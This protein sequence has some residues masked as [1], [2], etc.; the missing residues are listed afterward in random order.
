MS[1]LMAAGVIVS[2]CGD[3][4]D[5]SRVDNTPRIDQLPG[6]LLQAAD[7]P[8]DVH[9]VDHC[10]EPPP[11]P[12][13]TP[14]PNIHVVFANFQSDVSSSELPTC[15]FDMVSIVGS[16]ETSSQSLKTL[17]EG[18]GKIRGPMAGSEDCAVEEL[19]IP[20]LGDN[21]IA[22]GTECGS[23]PGNPPQM[24]QIGFRVGAVLVQ[25]SMVTDRC[26]VERDQAIEFARKQEQRIGEVLAGN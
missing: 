25:L 3:S 5:T 20:D 2:G 17:D 7:L 6:I 9:Q 19:D 15:V 12:L 10:G 13:P 1:A 16:P 18:F 11:F 8:D 23:C 22:Y 26:P 4:G 14:P 24:Y 21:R